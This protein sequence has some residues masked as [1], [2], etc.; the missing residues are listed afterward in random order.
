MRFIVKWQIRIQK[1]LQKISSKRFSSRRRTNKMNFFVNFT[2]FL[3]ISV[4]FIFTEKNRESVITNTTMLKLI[5][6]NI[7]Q[8]KDNFTV[9][10][11]R[12]VVFVLH[13]FE[14]HFQIQNCFTYICKYFS[15]MVLKRNE[16]F[17]NWWSHC[18]KSYKESI[19]NIICLDEIRWL[20]LT[21]STVVNEI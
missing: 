14:K 10:L 20:A 16:R 13:Q 5:W 11:L 8:V 21:K 17:G 6:R 4:F 15:L 1:F 7:L 18:G 19:K 2:E 9:L 12:A 3:S